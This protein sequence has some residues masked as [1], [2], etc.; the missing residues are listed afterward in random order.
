MCTGMKRNAQ[1]GDLPPIETVY[2]CGGHSNM[3][4]L[5]DYLSVGL[6]LNVVQANPWINCI[7]FERAIPEMPYEQSM[8]YVT[9]IGSRSQILSMINILPHNQKKVVAKIR[10]LRAVAITLWATTAL[11]IVAKHLLVP[12]LLR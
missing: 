11:G 8:S 3:R 1:Y 9:A 12:C 2:L 10:A 7:S 6:K 4:G 5:A